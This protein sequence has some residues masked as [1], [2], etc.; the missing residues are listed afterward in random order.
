MIRKAEEWCKQVL[1]VSEL[2]C[3]WCARLGT[4]FARSNDIPAAIELYIQV[5][6]I[7]LAKLDIS[8]V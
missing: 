8:R 3:V 1:K 6:W 7:S 2:D 5:S 4:T